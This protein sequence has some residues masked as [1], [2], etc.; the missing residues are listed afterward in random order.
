MRN[1]YYQRSPSLHA[2]DMLT[3]I[4]S[5]LC[6]W[7]WHWHMPSSVSVNDFSTP[8]LFQM[9]TIMDFR[10]NIFCFEYFWLY[11]GLKIKTAVQN[12]WSVVLLESLY[13]NLNGNIRSVKLNYYSDYPNTMIFQFYDTLWVQ[14]KY[15]GDWI[16]W[17]SLSTMVLWSDHSV[18]IEESLQ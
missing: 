13:I 18:C 2:T 7:N 3:C 6:A 14:S 5:T 9:T 8:E 10:P 15:C 4:L 11:N 17:L 16:V 1:W 12:I